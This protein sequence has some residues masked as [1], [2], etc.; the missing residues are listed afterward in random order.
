MSAEAYGRFMGRFSEPLALQFIDLLEPRQGQRALDVGCGPGALT[1]PLRLRLGGANVSAV[2]P[3]E[4]F[5]H[6]AAQRFPDTDVRLASAERL[7]FDDSC[8][9]LVVAQLVVHFMADPVAG[10]REMGRVTRPGGRVAAC[11]WDHSPGGSGPL[12]T[13]WEAVRSIDP[14]EHGEADLA[15]SREGQLG[16]LCARAGLTGIREGALTVSVPCATFAEWWDPFTLGV[17][18]S[19]TYVRQ[20][21][22]LGRQALRKECWAR[23]PPAPFE[24]SVSA[25]WVAADA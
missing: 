23:M 13:F 5:V 9:D 16:E 14:L 8:F 25:W 3:S 20:L 11:V 4:S 17:G 2:D 19:G 12:S 7:P 24:L 22:E 1:A 6:S 10:L 21:D 15:G 18:P